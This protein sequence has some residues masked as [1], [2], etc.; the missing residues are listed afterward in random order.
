MLWPAM[1]PIPE[2]RKVGGSNPAPDHKPCS[3]WEDIPIK[4]AWADV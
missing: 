1:I 3:T 4:S 2:K